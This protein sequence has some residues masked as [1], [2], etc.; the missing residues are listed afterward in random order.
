M[1]KPR[2]IENVVYIRPLS[3]ATL[4]TTVFCKGG[5]DDGQEDLCQQPARAPGEEGV[6]REGERREIERERERERELRGML[7]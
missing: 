4:R 3:L 1:S 5:G 6:E 7:A 2:F